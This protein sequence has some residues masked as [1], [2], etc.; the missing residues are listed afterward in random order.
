MMSPSVRSILIS[1]YTIYVSNDFRNFIGAGVGETSEACSGW[2]R[3]T[4]TI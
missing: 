2:A 4:Y 1:I 3:Y